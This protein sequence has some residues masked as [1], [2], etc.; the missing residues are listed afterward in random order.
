MKKSSPHARVLAYC[1][2]VTA[3]LFSFFLMFHTFSYNA[4]KHHIQIASKLWSDFGAHIP[5]IRSFS[6]GPNTQ[7]LLQGKPI[8]SPLFPG[9]PIRYHFGFYAVV[10]LLEK[11]G[12]RIDWAL[13]SISALG[14]FLLLR[15]LFRFS[16]VLFSS[17][18]IS[19]LS[20]LFFIFNGS[21]SFLAFF[22]QHPINPSTF[23]DII[24]NSKFPSFG[25]WDNGLVT[26]F[27]NLNIYT[28]QRHL[29]LSYGLVFFILYLLY[30]PQKKS[31][32]IGV[33]IG[34]ST[35]MLLFINFAAAGIA[36]LF[37]GWAFIIK[38]DTRASIVFASIIII[39]AVFVLR[40]LSYTSSPVTW[41]P[42]YLSPQPTP[43][44]FL[45]FWF[46]NLGLH[47]ILIP[48]GVL[49]APKHIRR[50]LAPPLI[51]LFI[52]PNL[53]KF[54]ADMIN[55]HKFFNFF[56][57]LGNIFSAYA[58]VLLIKL[59]NTV[60]NKWLKKLARG[61][62]AAVLITLLTL[63]GFIDL[64]P[65]FNDTKGSI[66]D[67]PANPD[68]QFFLSNTHPTEVIANSTWFYHPASIA[69]R[70]VLSGYTYFTWSYGYKQVERERALSQIYE[71]DSI[72]GVC[73]AARQSGVTH[74]ELN[75]NPES[76]LLPNLR[77]WQTITPLYENPESHLRIYK[78]A[79]ICADNAHE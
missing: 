75:Q 6:Y 54:S 5:L 63:S 79:D 72:T 60:R 28:N 53:F 31:Q 57:A 67:I 43:S 2:I 40:A 20:V 16:R 44:S 4:D 19:V 33:A 39:P 64:F 29:A 78:V 17:I 3:L 71:A 34:I 47:S 37:L 24:S 42:G 50:F 69:G 76:Y 68:A 8:E 61:L 21:L 11:I 49:C 23:I 12:M 10:G 9:E 26:A 73:T 55:N 62:T 65:I 45:L 32:I 15:A 41:Q 36:A 13:N 35:A 18:A 1:G 58:V 27:W 25:P 59:W 46:H 14:F 77:I 66:F 38:K 70:S 30:Q 74:I 7:R 52:L 48:I 22:Q 51:I 56:L